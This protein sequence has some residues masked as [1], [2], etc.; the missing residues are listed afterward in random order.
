MGAADRCRGIHRHAGQLSPRNLTPVS[1]AIL[2]RAILK[3]SYATR[4]SCIG[5]AYFVDILSAVPRLWAVRTNG[6][7]CLALLLAVLV[8]MASLDRVPD[9]PAVRPDHPQVKNSASFAQLAT[10]PVHSSPLIAM[11]QP[12]ADR[13]ASFAVAPVTH[14]GL[15]L[16]VKRATDSSPPI[17]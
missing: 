10:P 16:V 12:A 9:P 8:A 11:L 5:F 7:W 6:G 17:L 4:L 15:I 2:P 3:Y 14:R 13:G 1:L